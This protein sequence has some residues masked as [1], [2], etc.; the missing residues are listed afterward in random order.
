MENGNKRKADPVESHAGGNANH[1]KKKKKKS[2]KVPVSVSAKAPQPIQKQEKKKKT[3]IDELSKRMFIVPNSI[4]VDHQEK[5]NFGIIKTDFSKWLNYRNGKEIIEDE[6]LFDSNARSNQVF[7]WLIAPLSVEEFYEKYWEKKPLLIKRNKPNYYDG[8]FSKD[9][10]DQL[11]KSTHIEYG[12]HVDVTLY[13]N[14]QRRTLNPKG[15]AT[16]KDIWNFFAKGCSVRMLHPQQ[17]SASV[18]KILSVLEDFWECGGGCNSYLTPAG[19]QG[20]APHYDDVEAFV[21]QTEGAKHWKLYSPLTPQETLPRTSSENFTQKEIGKPI[22]ETDLEMGDLLYFPRGFI[23][24]AVSLPTCHSLHLTLSTGLQHSWADFLEIALPRAVQLAFD[25][26]EDFRQSLPRDFFRHIGVM[27]SDSPNEKRREYLTKVMELLDK[28]IDTIPIDASA[29]AMALGFLESRLPPIINPSSS[30]ILGYDTEKRE[31]INEDAEIK[32]TTYVTMVNATAARLTV[33]GDVAALYTPVR[34]KAALHANRDE[35]EMTESDIVL[36]FSLEETSAVEHMVT[37]YPVPFRVS[38]IPLE[39]ENDKIQFA[40]RLFHH[41]IL[42][43]RTDVE[44]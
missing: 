1:K 22:L 21:V 20:F 26:N 28:A 44:E 15:R 18:S 19:Y 36:E 16:A 7:A 31:V 34:N 41:G 32:G 42:M 37:A 35:S 9:E 17:Y 33:E 23:H 40:R 11:F 12:K 14:G 8:W 39:K 27:H 5:E 24:Q 25:E 43:I 13:E 38:S 4:D 3:S 29:D 30:I 10:M 2:Q 6:D